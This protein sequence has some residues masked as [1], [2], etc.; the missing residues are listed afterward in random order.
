[1]KNLKRFNQFKLKQKDMQSINGGGT[2]TLEE[3]C[4]TVIM[5]MQSRQAE[6]DREGLA[7]A[8]AAWDAHCA[9]T[10]S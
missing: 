8:G 2:V 3:Y 1:M 5:I 10:V 4:D 6:G 9:G 7:N